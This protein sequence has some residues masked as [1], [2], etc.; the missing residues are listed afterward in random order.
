MS[1]ETWTTAGAMGDA[2]DRTGT[3]RGVY[4]QRKEGVGQNLSNLYNLQTDKGMVGVWGG[5]VIDS[6]MSEVPLGSEV[7]ITALGEKKS[8]KT[9]KSYNDYDI[10]YRPAPFKTAGEP[11]PDES[12][13][14][15]DEEIS[16]L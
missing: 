5:A 16:Q 12:S 2:W 6:K 11:L 8:E 14:P 13:A 4:F 15:T 3:V 1:E 10:K 9:G 7:M